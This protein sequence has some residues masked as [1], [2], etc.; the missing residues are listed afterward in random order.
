MKVDYNYKF[1]EIW[2][3]EVSQ[4]KGR[5]SQPILGTDGTIFVTSTDNNIYAIK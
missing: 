1:K 2:N 4:N 3:I 5:L